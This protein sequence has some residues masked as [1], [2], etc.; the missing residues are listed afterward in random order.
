MS[1]RLA[2]LA[3]A[4]FL[5]FAA[6]VA[7]AANVQFFRAGALNASPLNPRN[8]MGSSLYQ[9]GKIVAADGE[10]LAE[11]VP[12]TSGFNPWQRVYPLHSLVSGV[13]GFDSPV[14]GTWALEAQYDQYLRAHTQ[15]ARS[16]TEVLA[17]TVAADNVNLTIYPALQ[18]VARTELAGRDG[19]V[20]VLDPRNGNVLAMFSN[21]NYDPTPL[22]GSDPLAVAA[23][24]KKINTGDAHHF[25]PLGLVA[26][27]ESFPPGS[28]FKVITTTAA[29]QGR[30]DLLTKKYPVIA[31]TKLPNTNKTLSN[32][33]F[34][35]CG[36][37]ITA[38][39]PPSCDTGYALL[40]L[41][42]G[43]DLLAS[44]AAE[45]GFNQVPPIDLPSVAPS[46]FPTAAEL[47][48]NLPEV[49]YSAIGQQNVRE[50]ALGNALVAAA[51]ANGGVMMTPHLMNYISGP[52][53]SIVKR[54]S[55]H[56]WLKSM[57]PT[58]TAFLVPLM[59]DV[60]KFGT[61]YGVFPGWIDAAAK[62][63]TAQVGNAAH[64]T[65]DWMIAFAPAT[66]PT[67]AVAVVLPFQDVSQTGAL[68]AGPVIKCVM[69]AAYAVQ[70]GQR[71]TGTSTTCPA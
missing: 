41:D 4:V 28:T 60:V 37:D 29:I 54:Y 63:G 43:G 1:R 44:T 15:P 21:P 30:P 52:D 62:T 7:Q 18:R 13:V 42:L 39:L 33:G 10:V 55:P 50:T 24:W 22:E 9:R 51:I 65:D 20:V 34:G 11:S 67:I 19:A 2:V 26:T 36:G 58:Q 12:A 48:Y 57:T 38:M 31:T 68:V 35:T 66:H 64:N 3:V 49:A 14:Q 23:Y 32:F 27:Q 47:K 56:P 61:A 45:F 70:H 69:L 53:G 46:A 40:G 6:V 71:P 25:P 8:T 17:P 59:Q 16:W 5:L